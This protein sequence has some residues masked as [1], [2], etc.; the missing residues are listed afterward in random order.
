MTRSLQSAFSALAS[1][2]GFTLIELLV[3]L[4]AGLVVFT[5]VFAVLDVTIHQSTRITSRADATQQGRSALASIEQDLSTSCVGSDASPIIG[6]TGGSTSTRLVYISGY[7][8]DPTVIPVKHQITFT[9]GGQTHGTLVD[10][11]YAAGGTGP[12]WTWT[13]TNQKL[14]L[15]DVDQTP[16]A[17]MFQYFAFE[18]PQS[19]GASYLDPGGHPFSMLLDGIS[20][21]PSEATL[22]GA[23][24]PSNTVPPKKPLTFGSSGELTT[25]DAAGTAEVIINLIAYPGGGNDLDPNLSSSADTISDAVNMRLT[26]APN[27]DT[28]QEVLPCA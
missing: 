5:A 28:G 17:P 22:G 12:N 16:T 11:R 10:Q 2:R 18:Q 21:L 20:P 25:A 23:P 3:T 19:G 27:H 24:V 4:S 13:P 26:P 8:D 1:E 14:L 6:G 7:G 15:S 9:P